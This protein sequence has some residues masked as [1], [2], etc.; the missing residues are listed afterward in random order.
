MSLVPRVY[1]KIAIDI[2]Q[3]CYEGTGVAR[4]I[5]QLVPALLHVHSAHTFVLFGSSFRQRER[6]KRFVEPLCAD[7]PR[8]SSVILPFPPAFWDVLWNR[9]HLVPIEWIIGNIDVFWSSDWTQPPVSTAVAVTTIHDISILRNPETFSEH[10]R[11]VH[12]RK[13][14]RSVAKCKAFFCDSEATKKDVHQ[15]L[16][17]PLEQLYVIYPGLHQGANL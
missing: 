13:L 17:I 4:Y 12:T 1:M 8:V 6:L 14:A 16:R 11:E 10:I 9:L 3:V 15:T 5:S 2:S 7:N